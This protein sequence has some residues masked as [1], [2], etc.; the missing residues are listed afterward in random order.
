MEHFCVRHYLTACPHLICPHRNPVRLWYYHHH[1]RMPREAAEMC[2]EGLRCAQVT[3]HDTP[4]LL[5]LAAQHGILVPSQ[6]SNP[7]PLH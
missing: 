7:C 4:L 5:F 2:P 1:L 3:H 6:E